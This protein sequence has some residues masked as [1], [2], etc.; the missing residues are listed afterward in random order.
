M[1][2]AAFFMRKPEKINKKT[3][4]LEAIFPK[5]SGVGRSPGSVT[6]KRV[7]FFLRDPQDRKTELNCDRARI[8][9][10]TYRDYPKGGKTEEW[11]L[12]NDLLI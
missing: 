9:T 10:T 5:G 7:T 12:Q 3:R 6:H 2:R 11:N 4:F 1:R 8:I